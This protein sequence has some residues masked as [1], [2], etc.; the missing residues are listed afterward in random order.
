MADKDDP[1][2]VAA[3]EA[4]GTT[5]VVCVA[6]ILADGQPRILFRNEIDSSHDKPAQ[7]LE[8]C[9]EFFKHH[10]PI[11]GYHGLG[12]AT[13]GPV[14]L[15]PC[16]NNYGCILEGS[17]KAAYRNV[18]LLKPLVSACQGSRNLAVKIETDVKDSLTS[19]AYVTV[20]TGVGVGL[21]INGACVHGCM[22][23]EGGHV[24]IQPLPGD[25]FP[26]YSWGEKSPFHGRHTVEGM[27]SSVALTERLELIEG[28]KNLPRSSLIE[29]DDGHEVWIHAANALAN[30]SATLILTTSIERIVFGGGI[31]NRKGL[32]E[33]IRK[34]TLVLLNGYL[35]LPEIDSLIACSSFG[36]DV[37][38]MGAILLAQQAHQI[39]IEDE[40]PKKGG[41]SAFDV[42][43]FHGIVIGVGIAYIGLALLRASS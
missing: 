21:V 39:S 33:K 31:M 40:V 28:K 15:V 13:F 5:F 43:V 22:H 35:E 32:I 4:G 16:R 19:V 2:I 20:G 29:L 38:L 42:G 34:R 30:L 6:Q 41:V 25:Q 7:T 36:S 23:P 26:G 11:N 27:A 24:P 17:P 12:V 3:L 10:K 18:D 8:Q 1:V 9:A 37:G 14:G